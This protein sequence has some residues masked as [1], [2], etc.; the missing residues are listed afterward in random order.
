VLLLHQ[1]PWATV[2]TGPVDHGHPA[3]AGAPRESSG[4]GGTA[5][6]L[7]RLMPAP[8]P[9]TL[10]HHS[11]YHNTT[12]DTNNTLSQSLD[13]VNT[14]SVVGEEEVRTLFVS[15]LPMDTKPRELYLLFRA[16]EGY[17]G[18][19]L[20]V[21]SKNGKTA[22]PVGF[23]T[24]STRAGAEAAKQDLQIPRT[25]GRKM[26]ETTGGGTGRRRQPSK[27]CGSILTY[28]RQSA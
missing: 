20:K 25:P 18:S 24:F 28:L 5:A 7:A 8:P 23:V 17:E 6:A 26:R 4:E 9:T 21:T 14:I 10:H 3:V 1:Q 12:M 27:V 22:S 16:Y 15:G 13:S 11:H 2:E 19:L